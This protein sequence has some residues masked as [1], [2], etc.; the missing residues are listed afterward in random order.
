MFFIY[1]LEY[2][3]NFVQLVWSEEVE[4]SSILRSISI[5][6]DADSKDDESGIGAANEEKDESAIGE[7]FDFI[8]I[9][10]RINFFFSKNCSF[11]RLFAK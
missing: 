8:S 9:F 5:V 4:S 6:V 7:Y 2:I 10:F 3:Q 11:I 1:N